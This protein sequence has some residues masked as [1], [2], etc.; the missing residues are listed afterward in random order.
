MSDG[1]DFERLDYSEAFRTLFHGNPEAYGVWTPPKVPVNA[2]GEKNKGESK[3]VK[4]T[5]TYA[6]IGEHL[7]GRISVGSIPIYG[8]NLVDF[9]AIDVDTYNEA[10]R[11]NLVKMI[12]EYSM[13][14]KP[15]KSKS[16][17]LHLFLFF[18]EPM[19]AGKVIEVLKKYLVIFNLDRKTE[20]FPK[21]SNIKGSQ[22]GNWIN[23]PYFGGD[24]TQRYLIK[25]DFTAYTTGEAM[26][27]LMNERTLIDDVDSFLNT[28]PFNDGPPCIQNIYMHNT[29]KRGEGRDNYLF[30]LARYWKAKEEV[31]IETRVIEANSRF[32]DPVPDKDVLHVA[33]SIVKSE[34]TYLCNKEPLVLVCKRPICVMREFG[35]EHTSISNFSFGQLTKVDSDPPIYKWIIDDATFEF[36]DEAAILNQNEFTKL[37]IRYLRKVPRRI[38]DSAW[39]KIIQTALDS[40]TIEEVKKDNDFSIGGFFMEF[41]TEYCETRGTGNPQFLPMGQVYKDIKSKKYYFKAH[42]LMKFLTDNKNFRSYSSSEVSIKLGALGAKAER[43]TVKG[44]ITQE[45]CWSL[46]FKAIEAMVESGPQEIDFL[47]R[48]DE[49]DF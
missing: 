29:L 31:D 48:I 11:N 46:P 42:A 39:R 17:G 45:R 10:F 36:Y 30:S 9:C 20:I 6:L 14:F 28:L 4:D 40:M 24:N 16:G 33:R 21:Q 19:D 13:P 27:K 47:T 3:T 44:I 35:I 23:L 26:S 12:Y 49:G 2:E 25:K 37:S 38:K 18:S 5:L 7:A 1:N 22:L 34:S 43:L 41:L 15:F 8:N 32:P